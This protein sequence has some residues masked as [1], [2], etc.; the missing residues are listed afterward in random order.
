MLAP[1]AA[2]VAFA[3]DP[4]TGRADIAVVSA[5]YGL[6]ARLVSGECDADTFHIDAQERI[7]QR[8]I[9]Q[10]T[11]GDRF[12]P[13]TGRIRS[14]AIQPAL[15]DQPVL[16]DR[17]IVAIA[18]LTRQVSERLGAPQDVEWAIAQQ[19]LYLLQARP[20]SQWVGRSQPAAPQG[21]YQLWDN[22]NIAESYSGVTTP[23]TF[24]FA[25]RAYGQVYRQ[26]CRLMGVSPVEIER[27]RDTFDHTLGFIQGR[28]YYNLLNWYRMLALLP[29]F[30][31]NRQFMEQMMGVKAG[32]PE[33][34]VTELEQSSWSARWADRW[35]LGRTAWV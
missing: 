11:H 8:Q 20:I 14:Q 2:G 32:L 21:C 10:K 3:G 34:L 19:N 15:V 17:E 7:V 16:G 22:S 25:R 27:H 23:L 18:Q 26:F 1:Q 29:G 5:V 4:V 13:E 6:S 9:A 12:D 31:A 30:R 28:F 35:R 24:S 33:E